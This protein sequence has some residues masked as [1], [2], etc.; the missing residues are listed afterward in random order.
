M[1]I[2]NDNEKQVDVN[3]TVPVEKLP[4]SPSKMVDLWTQKN[5]SYAREINISVKADN[6]PGGGIRVIKITE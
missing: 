1:V 5:M 6:T 2:G 3:I 4:F